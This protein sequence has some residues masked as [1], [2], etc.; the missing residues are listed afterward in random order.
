[1]FVMLVLIVI[2]LLIYF[3]VEGYKERRKNELPKTD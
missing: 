3:K 1:M 2:G